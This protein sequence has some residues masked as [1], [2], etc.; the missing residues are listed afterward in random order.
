M[1]ILVLIFIKTKLLHHSPELSYNHRITKMKYPHPFLY[2]P[3]LQGHLLITILMEKMQKAFP[4]CVIITPYH[5]LKLLSIPFSVVNSSSY[6]WASIDLQNYFWKW[7]FFSIAKSPEME[8]TEPKYVISLNYQSMKRQN[9][10]LDVTDNYTWYIIYKVKTNAL[11]AAQ[12][13]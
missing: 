12:M 1:Y 6:C 5:S 8:H 9:Y 4:S 13:P 11:L 10:Y 2:F 7:F 3:V